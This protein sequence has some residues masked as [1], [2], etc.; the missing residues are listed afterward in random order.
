MNST[1]TCG[2][3]IPEGSE[4]CPLCGR[5]LSEEARQAEAERD[6]AAIEL[7]RRRAAGEEPGGDGRPIG[8]GNPAALRSSSLAGLLAAFLSNIP[9]LYF[10]CFVWYPATGFLSVYLY[11]RR[12]GESPAPRE[13]ALLG[14]MTGVLTFVISLVIGALNSVVRQGDFA[15]IFREQIEQMAVQ[16]EFR[17]EMLELIENPAAIAFIVLASL[18]MTLIVTLGFSTA[19]G[20]LGAKVLEDDKPPGSE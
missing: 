18:L 9:P 14:A 17:S 4:F 6:R 5:P 1:C 7:T 20:A 13:G 11:R 10:L 15:E 2:A 12:T 16:E 8:F 3:A 19:G